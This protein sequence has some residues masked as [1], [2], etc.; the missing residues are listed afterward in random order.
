LTPI[1]RNIAA[2]AGK[3]LAE[4]PQG[5]TSNLPP[6]NISEEDYRAYL[7]NQFRDGLKAVKTQNGTNLSLES[8]AKGDIP[9]LAEFFDKGKA[10][11]SQGAIASIEA[12]LQALYPLGDLEEIKVVPYET[13]YNA[14]WHDLVRLEKADPNRKVIPKSTIIRCE[15]RG[16]KYK[17]QLHIRPKVVVAE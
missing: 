11:M 9:V 10:S 17:A 7:R 13:A 4:T 16:F 15:A 1:L 2:L 8:F 12:E 14:H 6:P 3:S 5:F